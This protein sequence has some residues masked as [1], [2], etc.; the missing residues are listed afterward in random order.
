MTA[1]PSPP[2]VMCPL[3]Y[4]GCCIS[5]CLPSATAR[6]RARR[7]WAAAKSA[8]VLRVCWVKGM[9]QRVSRMGVALTPA[10]GTQ[11]CMGTRRTL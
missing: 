1:A 2:L 8:W 9:P 11:A 6:R 3:L 4:A 10:Q 5:A 7:S